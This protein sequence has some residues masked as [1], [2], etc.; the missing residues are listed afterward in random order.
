MEEMT[1]YETDGYSKRKAA[2]EFVRW[3]VPFVVVTVKLSP[4][5]A[6]HYRKRLTFVAVA[7]MCAVVVL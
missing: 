7:A 1:H 4:T 2:R 5:L 6:W 3:L